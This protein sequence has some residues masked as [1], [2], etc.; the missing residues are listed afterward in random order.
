MSLSNNKNYL[1][2]KFIQKKKTGGETQLIVLNAFSERVKILQMIFTKN[3]V[4]LV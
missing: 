2:K 4:K 1:C 3:T